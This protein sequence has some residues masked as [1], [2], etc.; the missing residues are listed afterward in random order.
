[1][2]DGD[3]KAVEHVLL[4]ASIATTHALFTF[5]AAREKRCSGDMSPSTSL[6]PPLSTTEIH[7]LLRLSALP[8]IVQN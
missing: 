2:G 3:A 4:S 1:M 5:N 6:F 7:G 8:V